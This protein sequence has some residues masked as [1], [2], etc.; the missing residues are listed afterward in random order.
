MLIYNQSRP[1]SNSVMHWRN[2]KYLAKVSGISSQR[3]ARKN[4]APITKAKVTL[5]VFQ[6]LFA[7]FRVQTIVPSCIKGFWNRM[8]QVFSISRW[9]V[10]RKNYV[11]ISKVRSHFSLIVDMLTLTIRFFAVILLLGFAKKILKNEGPS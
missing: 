8:A 9:R 4:H 1:G 11:T 3:V 10:T 2:V 7:C 5:A 6:C